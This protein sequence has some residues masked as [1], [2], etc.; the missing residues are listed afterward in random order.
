M[1]CQRK[2]NIV[3][4]TVAN[5]KS[6]IKRHRQSLQRAGRNRAARTRVKNAIKQ[7]RS[8]ITATDKA[9]ANEALVAATSVLSKAA[10]KGAMHWLS[11]IHI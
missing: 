5:H 10:G 4:D 1:A 9:Q 3:E 6:A 11:L 8:A 7:V 2:P